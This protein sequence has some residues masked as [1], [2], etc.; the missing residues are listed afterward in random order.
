MTKRPTNI[1]GRLRYIRHHYKNGTLESSE[2]GIRIKK[3]GLTDV[4]YAYSTNFYGFIPKE[5]IGK[6]VHLSQREEEK[7]KRTLYQ[8]IYL[9]KN[10][11][12]MIDSF[13]ENFSGD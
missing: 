9:K 7:D 13:V 6:N 1:E 3:E 4:D 5:F 12:Y 8:L 11:D 2:I 10:P